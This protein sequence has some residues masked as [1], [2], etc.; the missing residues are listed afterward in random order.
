MASTSESGHAINVANFNRLIAAVKSY[1]AAYNPAKTAL[2]I[3]NLEQ[4]LT[5]A[6]AAMNEVAQKVSVY[7]QAVGERY[8]HFAGLKKFC[9]RVINAASA[10]D[11]APK[12]VETVKA[13]NKKIQGV[14]AG[15]KPNSGVATAPADT[16][17]PDGEGTSG[18]PNGGVAILDEKTHSTSQQSYEM[19]LENFRNLVAMLKSDPNYLPN[20]TELQITALEQKADAMKS[21][22]A[23]LATLFWDVKNARIARDKTFYS[24]VTGL[25]PI[26]MGVKEYVKSVYGANAA[27]FRNISGI[28]IK[29]K[30]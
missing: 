20:E 15:A 9:T 21:A 8:M 13:I 5:E 22:N 23:N 10:T 2:K 27:E 18:Q 16:T 4:V 26:Q 3:P 29:N 24:V 17:A 1:G 14:R 30:V 12:T 6:E 19:Q 7:N 11:A 28:A 25:Y